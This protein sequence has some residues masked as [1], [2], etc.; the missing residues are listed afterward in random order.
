MTK[1]HVQITQ[2]VMWD[3]SAFFVDCGEIDNDKII[4]LYYKIQKED[5]EG[6]TNSNDGGYQVMVDKES[7]KELHHLFSCIEDAATEIISRGYKKQNKLK[8]ANAWLNGNE[9]GQCNIVHTHPGAVLSGVYY[10]T[11][12]N[13]ENGEIHLTR[14]NADLLEHY[15]FRSDEDEDDRCDD[16][17]IAYN[18]GSIA[19]FPANASTAILFAPWIPH[20]VTTNKTKDIR[21]AIGLNFRFEDEN[22]HEKLEWNL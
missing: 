17:P 11:D 7:S 1:R 21:I 5:P 10:V 13:P 9:Y 4:E 6:K 3:E 14:P 19:A 16:E 15:R 8:I 22:D 20:Y 2:Q 12:T 18:M